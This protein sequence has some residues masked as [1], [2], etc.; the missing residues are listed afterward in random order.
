MKSSFR[1]FFFLFPQFNGSVG[2]APCANQR[3]KSQKD[4]YDRKGYSSRRIPE[5]SYPLTDKYLIH[6][7]IDGIDQT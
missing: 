2:A 3:G 4:R 5:I 6:N 7:I 1:L